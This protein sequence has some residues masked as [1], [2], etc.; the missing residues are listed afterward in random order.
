M[1]S[2]HCWRIQKVKVETRACEHCVARSM[3]LLAGWNAP[4][5]LVSSACLE[6]RV[7]SKLRRMGSENFSAGGN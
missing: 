7:I 5:L 1:I 6:A 3:H 4:A 2:R